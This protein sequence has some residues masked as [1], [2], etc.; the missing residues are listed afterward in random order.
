MPRPLLLL[1]SLALGLAT[2]TGTHPAAAT[3]RATTVEVARSH[4]TTAA[5]VTDAQAE[6][7]VI[8]LVNRKRVAHGCHA[9]KPNPALHRAA[10]RHSNK[11]AAALSLSHQLPGEPS[12]GRR[13]TKAGYKHWTRVGENV[14]Y[15]Y[16]TPAS[17]VRGW[18]NSPEHRANILDCRYKDTGVGLSHGGGYAWWTQDFGRK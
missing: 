3:S 12:L 17:V 14:A 15:G 11:M 7:K 13:V 10:K 8:R 16:P 6:R 4:Y 2:L 5:R 18:M 1:V 9:L